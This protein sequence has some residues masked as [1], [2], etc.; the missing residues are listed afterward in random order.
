VRAAVTFDT[1]LDL[2]LAVPAFRAGHR[3]GRRAPSRRLPMFEQLRA[4][5]RAMLAAARSPDDRREVLADMKS[6]VVRA[7]MGLDDL[8]AGIADAER[9]LTAGQ[10]EL[11][12]IRRRRA[13]AEQIGDAE[14][15]SVA[16]RFEALQV[17]R[18]GVLERK[19]ETQQA[20]LA[21]VE[22]EVAEMTTD[23]RRAMDGVP[24]RD[25]AT[26]ETPR[27]AAAAASAIE[28]GLDD[29]LDPDAALRGQ[30]DA[31]DRQ[32]TR[33]SR[34]ADADERLA[35]LKRKLGKDT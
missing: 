8:R 16:Q 7:R 26:G 2:S 13:M 17:E 1:S 20:E 6:S 5:F 23:L 19:L 31:L 34:E 32:Q 22:R 14:T 28:S 33:T 27:E 25:V 4:S 29:M 3:P 30:I 12:T 24:L 35:A 10:A 18:V 21:L 15:V 9:R 11:E